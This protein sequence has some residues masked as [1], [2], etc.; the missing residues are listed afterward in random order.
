MKFAIH[1]LGYAENKI[2]VHGWSIGGYTATWAAMNYPSIH[3]LVNNLI[4]VKIKI[5]DLNFNVQLRLIVA[6]RRNF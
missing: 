5:L 6:F 4:N 2:I 1:K 3:S